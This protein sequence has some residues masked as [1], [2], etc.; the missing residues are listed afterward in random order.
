MTPELITN[1]DFSQGNVGFVS[2]YTYGACFVEGNYNV[3]ANASTCHG[4]WSGQDHTTPGTGLFMTA[5]GALSPNVTVWQ[6]TVPVQQGTDYRLSIWVSSL[7][8]LSPASLTF[9]ING[10]V[11][12]SLAA[13]S[14]VGTWIQFTT[15]WNSSSNSSATIRI[16]DTNINQAGNDF[17]LDDLSFTATDRAPVVTAPATYSG[18][19]GALLQFSVNA[20]DPDGDAIQSL[21]ATSLPSGASFTPDPGNT[22]GTFSWTPSCGQAG[23]YSVTFT[24]TNVMAASV[25]TVLSIAS[26][27]RVQSATFD[28]A[29][30]TPGAQATLTVT[31]HSETFSGTVDVNPLVAL[32]YWPPSTGLGPLSINLSP[33]STVSF[34]FP[35]TVPSSNGQVIVDVTVNATGSGCSTQGQFP[36]A[37]VVNQLTVSNIQD[38]QQYVQNCGTSLSVSCSYWHTVSEIAIDW[39]PI[40]GTVRGVES[41]KQDACW[42]AA[43]EQSGRHGQ[44]MVMALLSAFDAVANSVSAWNDAV[45]LGTGVGCVFSLAD[46]IPPAV[47]DA[48]RCIVSMFDPPSLAQ[49]SNSLMVGKAQANA[50]SLM[51]WLPDSLEAAAE[52]SGHAFANLVI[53]SGSSLLTVEADSSF[54]TADSV[55]IHRVAVLRIGANPVQCAAIQAGASRPYDL[56]SNPNDAVTLRLKA[57]TRDTCRVTLFHR[58]SDGAV[59]KLVYGPALLEAGGT[60]T[61][62]T[63]RDSTAFVFSIDANGDNVPDWLLYPGQFVTGVPLENPTQSQHPSV[64]LLGIAPNPTGGSARIF[65]RT[66]GGALPARLVIYDVAGRKIADSALGILPSGDKV[67]TWDGRNAKGRRVASGVYFVQV[68]YP[69]ASSARGRFLMLR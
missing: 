48:T 32:R 6:Q 53:T 33:G 28:R 19:E 65:V 9:F 1:G 46:L 67:F 63:S 5:N 24:A 30:Y 41:M 45:C 43:Y 47:G 39:I 25:S 14:T 40:V 4:N 59:T 55:G 37:S 52:A 27:F 7:H 49:G 12:G 36:N 10:E 18:T 51:A 64:R 35:W 21:T 57:A 15:T 58:G 44:A 22:T 60:A 23:T 56:G 50:D 16:V 34:P 68:M 3:V 61:L 29:Q 69:G 2:A 38:A 17:G 31:L 26:A 8:T 66:S 54:A 20:S 42:T 13:P 62:H 11:A